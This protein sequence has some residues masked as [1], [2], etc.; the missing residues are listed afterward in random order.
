MIRTDQ[1][2]VLI[3]DDEKHIRVMMKAVIKRMNYKLAGEAEDGQGAI[4]LYKETRPDILLLDI[5][6]PVKSGVEV[7]KEII[8]FDPKAFVIILTSV[9][10]DATIETCL[11]AG[12]ANYTQKN[13]TIVDIKNIISD[14]W[15]K[16]NENK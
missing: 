13:A 3:A 5:K 10:D 1:P 4:D 15:K 16:F 11:S 14:S 7:L 12:A 6:M 8:E 9:A 2:R